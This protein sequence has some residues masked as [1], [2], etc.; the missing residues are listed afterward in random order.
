VIIDRAIHVQRLDRE[1]RE[2][3]E[4]RTYDAFDDLVGEAPRCRRSLRR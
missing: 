1:R 2:L 3:V 4:K